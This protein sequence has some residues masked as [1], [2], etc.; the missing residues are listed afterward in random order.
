M[1]LVFNK[2]V[3]HDQEKNAMVRYLKTRAAHPAFPRR[4][5]LLRG[6]PGTGKSSWAQQELKKEEFMTAGMGKSDALAVQLTHVCS[7]DDFFMEFKGAAT[8]MQYVFNP[9]QLASHHIMNQAR[10]RVAM[11]IGIDPL[12][13]DNHNMNLWDMHPYVML[14]DRL[15]YVVSVV[16]PQDISPSWN[17]VSYLMTRSA[18]KHE[19]TPEQYVGQAAL[20]AMLK[21]FEPLPESGDVRS[22]IR[23]GQ[24]PPAEAGKP[25]VDSSSASALLPATAVL[26]RCEKLLKEGAQ[27]FYYTPADGQGWGVNGELYGEWHSFKEKADGVCV[28]DDQV[29]QSYTADPEVGWSLVELAMLADLRSEASALPRAELPTTASNPKLFRREPTAA[30]AAAAAAPPAPA[31]QSEP[32]AKQSEA[33]AKQSEPTAKQSGP[34]AKQSEPPPEPV[35]VP[36]SRMER[37][38]RRFELVLAAREVKLNEGRGAAPQTEAHGQGGQADGERRNDAGAPRKTPAETDDVPAPTFLAA[39]KR[40]LTEWAKLEDYLEFVNILAESVDTD[41]AMWILRGH[42]D[43]LRV[44]KRNFA[45]QVDYGLPPKTE[46]TGEAADGPHPPQYPPRLAAVKQELDTG[47][48]KVVAPPYAAEKH[49]VVKQELTGAPPAGPE[50]P[51]APPPL[52]KAEV[53]PE[54]TPKPPPCAPDSIRAS[55][56]IGEDSDDEIM[57]EASIVAAVKKGRDDCIAELVK[58]VFRKERA[59]NES[60]RERLTT[61]H[62]MTKLTAKPRFPRE[63]FILRGAP[64]T[65]KTGYAMQ[66]LREYVDFGQD[67]ALAARLTHVC[68]ADDFYEQFKEEGA[69]Y[70]FD[71]SK[72]EGH[73]SRN[74]V[75]VRLAMEAGV[76]P[77]Y[78]DCANL[79]LW[80][81][82]SFVLL[83]EKLGYVAAV[84]EPRDICEQ[85]SNLQFLVAAN[86]TAERRSA[87]KVVGADMLAAFLKEFEPLPPA[88]DPL[89]AVRKAQREGPRTVEAPPQVA[90]AAGAKRPLPQPDAANPQKVPRTV[91]PPQHWPGKGGAATNGGPNGGRYW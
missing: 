6:P 1:R 59:S 90:L 51:P 4:L 46:L 12:F 87:G 24:S 2:K 75:R 69:V 14:A 57:D 62:Y 15:G 85:W 88:R 45:P 18:A 82:R 39:V 3:G 66:Q 80:E 83:A 11:E 86:D 50:A 28:Y 38:K 44:F 32:P 40:R 17:T 55:V 91:P 13:V 81:M 47:G 37:F 71:V 23:L 73:H 49:A 72:L 48:G 26:Y 7:A 27:L 60:A 63:L 35:E 29:Q 19:R 79:R 74:E 76:H 54:D 5:V 78:V 58:T 41:K 65:G 25:A 67:E 53:A 9:R 20:E 34:P 33:T 56:T 68:A 61:L 89:D 31:K 8:D 36:T 84:V 43:L 10:V 21:K 52:V 64:G 16:S 77:L 42:D 22:A 70:N 30:E